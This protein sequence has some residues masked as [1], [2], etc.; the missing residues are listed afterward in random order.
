MAP[1]TPLANTQNYLGRWRHTN[2]GE[3]DA[4]RDPMLAKINNG[5]RKFVIFGSFHP[6]LVLL[7]SN[8]LRIVLEIFPRPNH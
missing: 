4:P 5:G 1:S 7:V 8:R 3:F 2:L 6:I